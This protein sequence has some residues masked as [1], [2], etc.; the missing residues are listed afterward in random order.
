MTRMSFEVKPPFLLN[1]GVGFGV[2]RSL[3]DV[4]MAILP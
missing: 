3:I 2:G 4:G 1:G